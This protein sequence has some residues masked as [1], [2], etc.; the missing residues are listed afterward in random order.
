MKSSSARAVAERP[1]YSL[2]ADAYDAL[3]TD[4]VEPW[5]DAIHDRLVQA[6]QPHAAVLDAG[7]G[8][9]RQAAALIARGHRVDVA[10]ASREL[11]SRASERCPGARALLVDLCAMDVASEY[12][13][14]TCRG[15]LNDMTTDEERESAIGSLTACLRPGGLL[16]LDVREAEASRLRADGGERCRIADLGDGRKLR[17]STRTRWRDGRLLVEERYV[18]VVEGRVTHES[19]YDFAMR[20]WSRAELSSML[21]GN[22]MLQIDITSGVGR[23]TA[24]RLFVVAS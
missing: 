23:R 2:H 6:R 9:G 3:I 1:F 16:F 17:F 10:D 18:L 4:P 14:V 24:D 11:L 21:R 19:T 12:D 22:G 15:V 7:C 13:A 8:T 5:V 20:P